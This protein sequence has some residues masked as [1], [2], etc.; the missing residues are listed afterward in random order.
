MQ[1]TWNE[2]KKEL[3]GLA[4]AIDVPITE[5]RIRWYVKIWEGLGP[6]AVLAGLRHWAMHTKAKR[7]PLPGEINV[8]LSGEELAG[9]ILLAVRRRGYMR[10]EEAKADLGPAWQ[11]IE[12]MGGWRT[13]CE[14]E[15]TTTTTAQ[16]RDLWNNLKL[17]SD[18][19]TYGLIC[20]RNESENKISIPEGSVGSIIR[21]VQ[22]SQGSYFEHG[23]KNPTDRKS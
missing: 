10:P 23:P 4:H 9:T 15:W 20:G 16:T 6:A 8:D 22:E 11:V 17:R 14:K 18:H 3:I 7:L 19:G 2:V 13:V 1:T 12:L 5:N 21:G